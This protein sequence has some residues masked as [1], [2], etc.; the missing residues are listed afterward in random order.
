[1]DSMHAR[2][3]DDLGTRIAGYELPAG[4]VISLA[5][6]ATRYGVS[7]TVAR[8]TI[9]LLESL[10]MVTARRRVGITV[11]VESDWQVLNPRVIAWRLQG[12]GREAQLRSL[13]ELRAAVEPTAARL[14]ATHADERDVALLVE[15]ANCLTDLGSRG[16]GATEEYLATDVRFHQTL[17]RCSGN[18]MLAKLDGV[19][20]AVL[21]GR[22]RLGLTPPYPVREVMEHHDTTARAIRERMPDAAETCCRI[23]VNRIRRELDPQP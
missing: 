15:L 17:L 6:V 5:E 21:A 11:A 10:G 18:E 13:T 8:E 12:P 7:R 22:H 9:R 14:A 23:L 1:M 16:L 19:V 3:A 4:S 20:E 2:V